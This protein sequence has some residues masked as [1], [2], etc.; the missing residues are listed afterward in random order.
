MPTIFFSWQADTP[1]KEG[2][3]FIERALE[4]AIARISADTTL[5][6][7][8]RELQLDR[9]TKGVP[10][11]PPI[12]ETIFRKI[13]DAAVFVPDLT[14][15]GQRPG[16]SLT[17]NPN[18]LIEYGWAL[19]SLTHARIV[20][21]MNTAFGEP[22]AEN[23]PFDMRHLRNP[24][25]YSCSPDASETERQRVRAELTKQLEH[26]IRAVLED[27]DLDSLDHIEPI[28]FAERK[29]VDGR[30]RFQPNDQPL[31]HMRHGFWDSDIK[32]LRLSTAP[33]VWLRV[34]PAFEQSKI[35]TVDE[36]A[37][38]NSHRFLHPVSRDWGGF[39]TFR[40][41][42]GFATYASIPDDRT[43]VRGL[44][45]AFTT[46]EIW[47]IDT[48]WLEL[49]RDASQRPTI[50]NTE[51]DFRN[52]LEDYAAF[53]A[54]L[55]VA[56]PFKW[57]AGMENLKNRLL[58]IPAPP[59]QTR[60][61]TGPDGR[62]VVDVIIKSGAFSPGESPAAALKPFF[63]EIYNACGQPRRDWQDR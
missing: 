37:V 14:F 6:E 51:S 30:G 22:T 3:N 27:R 36:L 56:P 61:G 19:K 1:N 26:A 7:A 46:G 12:V 43:L 2:R 42:E 57:I 49:H 17:P 59:R 44:A 9:D 20:P 28:A 55:G 24:L 32:E 39:G 48:L 11:T 18:V 15:V 8:V 53:L 25:T 13:E 33:A 54:S 5:E 21:V 50:P 4:K 31:G 60:M 58:Y 34:M 35:F 29:P 47:S 52:A 45:F 62:C 40:T 63:Q 10:G 23:M 38:A 41:H 16:G